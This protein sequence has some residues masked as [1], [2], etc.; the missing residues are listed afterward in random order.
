MAYNNEAKRLFERFGHQLPHAI[1]YYRL[2]TIEDTI[3]YTLS[4][5]LRGMPE[6]EDK[7]QLLRVLN[8]KAHYRVRDD[9]HGNHRY[10][11]PF[12]FFMKEGFQDEDYVRGL[13]KGTFR[14]YGC[15][16][17]YA[18]TAANHHDLLAK[19]IMVLGCD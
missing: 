1:K 7:E 5:M 14:F 13:L 3:G 4:D 11:I 6:S 17:R 8:C 10:A 9:A 19:V 12:N 15:K 16:E 2:S 18:T